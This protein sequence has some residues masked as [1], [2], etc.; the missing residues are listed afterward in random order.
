MSP[1]VPIYLRDNNTCYCEY[2]EVPDTIATSTQLGVLQNVGPL[3][4]VSAS[5]DRVTRILR[6][7][8]IRITGT[9]TDDQLRIEAVNGSWIWVLRDAHWHNG[10]KPSG[11]HDEIKLGI[12]PD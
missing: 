10:I 1:S 2:G 9:I 5:L 6:N 7:F 4:V 11:A 8:G 12:W 3:L